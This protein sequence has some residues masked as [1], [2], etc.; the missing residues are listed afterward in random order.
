M[1]ENLYFETHVFSCINERPEGHVRGCCK[2]RGAV[3]LQNY[4]KA[5]MKEL[6]LLAKMRA[7]KSLCLDR[8]EEGPVLVIYP[9][10]TWYHYKTKDD[11]D[12]IIDGHIMKGKIVEH[13]KLPNSKQD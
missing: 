12:A 3:P 6:G 5:R 9:K 1:N 2:S 10:G 11:I 7:N 8:C 4:M 13:L